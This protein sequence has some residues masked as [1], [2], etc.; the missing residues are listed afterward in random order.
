MLLESSYLIWNTSSSL[1]KKRNTLL[2][3]VGVWSPRN[4]FVTWRLLCKGVLVCAFGKR[5]PWQPSFSS[6]RSC[7]VTIMA[8]QA[9]NEKGWVLSGDQR[10]VSLIVWWFSWVGAFCGGTCNTEIATV[11]SASVC[12]PSCPHRD[13]LSPTFPSASL[14]VLWPPAKPLS[15]VCVYVNVLPSHV[16]KLV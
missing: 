12:A 1:V 9:A 3:C 6:P 15:A 11:V 10:I 7:H 16:A 5:C 4:Q 14:P 2:S 8:G 13:F